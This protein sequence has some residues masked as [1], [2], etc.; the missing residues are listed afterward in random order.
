MNPGSARRPGEM[1]RSIFAFPASRIAIVAWAAPASA[2][3]ISSIVVPLAPLGHG[4]QRGLRGVGASGAW[5][6]FPARANSV[7]SD[8]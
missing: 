6:G 1:R 3:A 7:M 2:S 8:I 4:D 5:L